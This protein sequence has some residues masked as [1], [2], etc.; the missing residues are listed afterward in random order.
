M[1]L[2]IS[3]EWEDVWFDICNLL[4]LDEVN[5]NLAKN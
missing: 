5:P 2:S 1:S 3:F 4:Y